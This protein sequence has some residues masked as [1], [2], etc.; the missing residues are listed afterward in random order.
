MKTLLGILTALFLNLSTLYG[1]STLNLL[2]Y[3]VEINNERIY[4]HIGY[5]VWTEENIIDKDS[6]G[7]YVYEKCWKCPYC[8]R[9]WPIGVACQ[10]PDCPSKYK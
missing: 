10:N 3:V 8:F 2:D 5:N 9:F 4:T 6:P 1:M 7:L